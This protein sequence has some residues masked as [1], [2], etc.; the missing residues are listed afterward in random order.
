MK[1][2]IN[3]FNKAVFYGQWVYVSGYT[4]VR[5]GHKEY[6]HPHVRKRPGVIT[7]TPKPQVG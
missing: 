5:N 1:T 7:T 3:S 6:V 2:E 4:R